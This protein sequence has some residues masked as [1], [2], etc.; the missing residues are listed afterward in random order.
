MTKSSE[1]K[2]I[3]ITVDE[4]NEREKQL[5]KEI[6]GYYPNYYPTEIVHKAGEV[7]GYRCFECN[8]E[9]EEDVGQ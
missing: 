2:I 3:K 9:V 5:E 1:G 4:Y 8:N 6:E 7:K